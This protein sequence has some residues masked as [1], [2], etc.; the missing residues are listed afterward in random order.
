MIERDSKTSVSLLLLSLLALTPAAFV[1]AYS[2]Q[3]TME[4]SWEDDQGS[5]AAG[6]TVLLNGS[7]L[8]PAETT[9]GLVTFFVGPPPTPFQRGDANGDGNVDIADAVRMLDSLF[10]GAP[11]GQRDELFAAEPTV[12]GEL[13]G[14][15]HPRL[16]AVLPGRG[17]PQHAG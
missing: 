6:N 3:E 15:I 7:P 1:G 17:V 11:L 5:I 4:L 14:R 10:F 13:R 12:L 16:V 9:D 2:S 8:P